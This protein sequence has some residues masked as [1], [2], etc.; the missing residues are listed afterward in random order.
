MDKCK[1]REGISESEYESF[2]SITKE[3]RRGKSRSEAE[4][5]A[6]TSEISI[7]EEGVL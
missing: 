7:L 4:A 5:E 2:N 6:K 1:R 3:Q